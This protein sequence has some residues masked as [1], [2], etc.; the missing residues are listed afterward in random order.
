MKFQDKCCDTNKTF[1]KFYTKNNSFVL[2]S[3]LS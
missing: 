3:N 1:W 2:E